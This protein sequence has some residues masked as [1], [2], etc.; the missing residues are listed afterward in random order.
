MKKFGSDIQVTRRINIVP[1]TGDPGSLTNGDIWYN[2]TTGKAMIQQGGVSRAIL[3]GR[4]ILTSDLAIANT[5]T[6]VVAYNSVAGELYSG[7]TF[8]VEAYCTQAGTQTST[9]TIRIRIG[10]T[11]L[12]GNIAATLTGAAGTTA[13]PSWYKG[14]VTFRSATTAL[15]SLQGIKQAI[16]DIITPSSATV[17]ADVSTAN[18]IELTFVSGNGS[19]TYT[20]RNAYIRQI[21]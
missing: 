13:V 20:F 21:N 2:N 9:P 1:G 6:V 3:P 14:L 18:R 12:T 16:A 17:A 4:T 15:G 5:E 10:T 8:E 7:A 19:N 11:T